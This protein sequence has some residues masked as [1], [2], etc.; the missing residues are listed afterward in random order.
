[1]NHW[2][3][4]LKDVWHVIHYLAPAIGSWLFLYSICLHDHRDRDI[5]IFLSI[6]GVLLYIAGM[7]R[8]WL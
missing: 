5:S 3:L 6:L 4:C 8:W 2:L 7:N 1:M